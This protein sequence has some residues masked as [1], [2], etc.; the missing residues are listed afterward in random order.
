MPLQIICTPKCS[1]PAIICDHCGKEITRAADGNYQ[2]LPDETKPVTPRF[3]HK[4]CFQAFDDAHAH[5]GYWHTMELECFPVY[6]ANVL[7]V[8]W[9]KA[10][11][12]V[13]LFA[14]IG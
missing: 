5:L 11:D 10:V 8:N 1:R 2:W 3:T 9:K 13:K 14:R 12:A 6:L 4:A 7:K